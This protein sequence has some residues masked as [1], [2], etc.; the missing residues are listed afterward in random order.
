MIKT[1]AERAVLTGVLAGIL[2][3][4]FMSAFVGT[5]EVCHYVNYYFERRIAGFDSGSAWLLR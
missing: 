3:E 1:L 4:V 2:F 5:D